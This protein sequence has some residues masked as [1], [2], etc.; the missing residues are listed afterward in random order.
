[1]IGRKLAHYD[2]VELIGAG[3][4]GEVYRAQ[5]TRLGR[6]V[7][8]KVLHERLSGST[9]LRA[10][11]EREARVISHLSHPHIC[12]LHDIGHVSGIDFLVMEYL[13]GETLATKL[14]RGPLPLDQVLRFGAQI[15]EG[16]A[17]AHRQGVVHRDLKPGNVMLTDGGVKILDFG[18]AKLVPPP[19][20]AD[21][22]LVAPEELESGE[23]L[24]RRGTILGTFQYMAPEQLE[25]KKADA[26]TDIFALGT[27]LYEM[28]TGNRPFEEERQSLAHLPLSQGP[29]VL[30]AVLD[31]ETTP[32]S[33]LQRMTP[34]AL[35]WTVRRCL[36]RDPEDRWQDARD[37]ASAMRWVATGGSGAGLSL[38]A[39]ARRRIRERLAW[40]LAAVGVV[41]S[42]AAVAFTVTRL[43]RIPSMPGPIHFTIPPPERAIYVDIPCLSPDGR[44]LAFN[45]TDDLGVTRIWLRPLAGDT[46]HPLPGT[47]GAHRP[48]WSPDSRFLGFF[49]ED[50]FKKIEVSGGSAFEVCGIERAVDGAWGSEDVILFDGGIRDSIRQIPAGGGPASPATR[51]D[52]SRGERFHAWPQFL[53]DS[54]HFLYLA[55]GERQSDY[56]G[57]KVGSLD[58]DM[59]M[60]VGP[61]ESR[62][63]YAAPGYLVFVRGGAL[64]A[65]RFS[66]RSLDLLGE[67]HVIADQ[68]GS[69]WGGRTAFSVSGTDVLAYSRD[70]PRRRR[71]GWVDRAGRE[72]DVV[73]ELA[74][75]SGPRLSPDGKRIAVCIWDAPRVADIWL[76]DTE[77]NTTSR[78]TFT[79]GR[80]WMPVW[81]PDGEEIA[82]ASDREGP[83]EMFK[84]SARGAHTAERL[85]VPERYDVPVDWS[86][87]GRL[88]AV[89]GWE[90]ESRSNILLLP[91]DEDGESVLFLSS[92]F[93]ESQARFSPDGKYLA[94]SS[95]ET[96]TG[97]IYVQS[98]PSAEGKWQISNQG[99]TEPEWRRDGQE[100]YYLSPDRTMMSVAVTTDP[101]FSAGVPEPLFSAPVIPSPYEWNRYAVSADGERFLL[102]APVS[103]DTAPP[104][105]IIVNWTQGLAR[106]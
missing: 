2:I 9:E 96:G 81:S 33:S 92:P 102:V 24:T 38:P 90:E 17:V 88:I 68:V 80:D 105:S 101:A 77:R 97:E 5:D 7:A 16:L 70:Q 65:Q 37:V 49:A 45:A 43:G 78:F 3:G 39:I 51:I 83:V 25:G 41:V 50:S 99:G 19:A 79:P 59:T 21:E 31:R 46:T 23:P 73:G 44:Y 94:Y 48:F 53:P 85:Q 84:K 98:Y 106:N 58:S 91:T 55:H 12:V 20:I 34:P 69:G 64:V 67:P 87:D 61:C 42:I 86:A 10:R 6:T 52:R 66:T 75:Y 28:A 62:V 89:V 60:L 36:S 95:N 100:L 56:R 14:R 103:A 29:S 15:A 76:I 40:V 57:L 72:L 47:E 27:V 26:R 54:R 82:F 18:L 71:L 35:D 22:S 30:A 32:V 11:F 63:E 4:M 93:L 104:I 13:E 8:I 74:A 1:M